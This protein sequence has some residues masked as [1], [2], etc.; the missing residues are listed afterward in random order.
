MIGQSFYTSGSVCSTPGSDEVSRY[1][2]RTYDQGLGTMGVE[3]ISSLV[4][5][6]AQTGFATE[7]RLMEAM[8]VTFR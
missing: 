6:L 1:F 7:S 2:T 5:L 8:A 3:L 4:G